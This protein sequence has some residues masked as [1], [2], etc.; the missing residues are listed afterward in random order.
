MLPVSCTI[1]PIAAVIVRLVIHWGRGRARPREGVDQPPLGRRRDPHGP[2]R[3]F[4][5]PPR[6]GPPSLPP[7]LPRG[8][9]DDPD[10]VPEA[11]PPAR[12]EG[13]AARRTGRRRR[14]RLCGR[15]R[16]R[17]AIQRRIP[18][19]VG[20]PPGRDALALRKAAVLP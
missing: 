17:L 13:T 8:D 11:D 2:A 5:P 20:L 15:L 1:L 9:L 14:G 18:A 6:R 16:L 4:G 19:R 10:P 7:P 12:G 3:R